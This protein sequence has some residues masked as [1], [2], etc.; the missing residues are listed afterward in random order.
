M[1]FPPEYKMPTKL[2]ATNATKDFYPKLMFPEGIRGLKVS[3]EHLLSQSQREVL[4]R[5]WELNDAIPNLSA[6]LVELSFY[7]CWEKV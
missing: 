1:Q 4:K 2:T 7:F 3:F 5:V 6:E